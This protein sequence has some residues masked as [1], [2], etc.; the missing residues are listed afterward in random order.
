MNAQ[1]LYDMMK[2]VQ[3]P[4]GYFF[5]TDTGRVFELLDAL[6]LNKQRYGYM[7]CPCRLLAGDRDKDRDIICPC[8][9]S[10]PDIAEYGSCYCNLY[11]S[12]A[13]NEGKLARDYVPERRPPEK[14]PF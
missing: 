3:E 2:K 8:V 14:M 11:E 4:K 9:Y 5:N 12:K 1:Q 10:V 13:W 6:I 7:G